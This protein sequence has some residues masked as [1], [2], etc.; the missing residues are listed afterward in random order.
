[1]LLDESAFTD[2]QGNAISTEVLNAAGFTQS[3]IPGV[4]YVDGAEQGTGVGGP[5]GPGVNCG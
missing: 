1:M 5:A 4:Y 2:T 3:P